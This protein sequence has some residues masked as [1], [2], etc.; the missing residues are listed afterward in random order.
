MRRSWS[1]LLRGRGIG[2]DKEKPSLV[3]FWDSSPPDEV[4]ELMAT[5]SSDPAFDYTAFDQASADSFIEARFDAETIAAFRQ[6]AVPA[7]QADFFRYCALY[8][9]AGV[10]IDADISNRG[11]LGRFT[12]PMV[13]GLLITRKDVTNDV[14][15]FRHTH[16]PLLERVIEI[17]T[18]RIR[19]RMP[20]RVWSVTGPSILRQIRYDPAESH[21]FEGIDIVTGKV[22][23]DHVEFHWQMEYKSGQSD[24][25]DQEHASIYRDP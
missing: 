19:A 15:F 9:L 25:R 7:M 11:G 21:L 8:E 17:A 10:Y 18:Q 5:W 2:A 3:Q 13:R 14:M 16:D 6:C 24:W 4:A 20:G 22:I 1:R 12:A 23:R